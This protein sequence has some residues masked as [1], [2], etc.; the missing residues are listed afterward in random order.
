M[1]QIGTNSNNRGS[2]HPVVTRA[3]LPEARTLQFAAVTCS[4]FGDDAWMCGA[5]AHVDIRINETL[6][7]MNTIE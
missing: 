6:D 2:T 7:L 3:G 4:Y 1:F 5:S